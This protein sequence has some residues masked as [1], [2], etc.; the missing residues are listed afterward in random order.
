MSTQ[1]RDYAAKKAAELGIDPQLALRIMDQE[2]GGRVDAIS[3][4]GAT[5]L[6]QLMPATAKEVGVTDLNDPYQNIDGG[7]LYFK[8]QL[9]TFKDPRLALAAYNAGPGA[10]RKYNGIP[11]FKETQDYVKKI[12]DEWKEN[13]SVSVVPAAPAT[14]ATSNEALVKADVPKVLPFAPPEKVV[15]PEQPRI[16]DA[17][18]G[19]EKGLAA[20]LAQ[21]END[22]DKLRR[23]L[24]SQ[25]EESTAFDSHN[26][27]EAVLSRYNVQV[28]NIQEGLASSALNLSN[29]SSKYTNR[30]KF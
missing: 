28:P 27:P 29:L 22:A 18:L 19:Y 2:S 30:L 17:V 9:D 1:Y 15:T 26:S 23:E 8:W 12:H 13:P 25:W 21:S 11:P 16:P 24:I 6:F 5:G 20:G 14:P 7:L 10:V 3:P 4:K